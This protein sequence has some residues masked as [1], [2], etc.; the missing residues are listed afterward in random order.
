MDGFYQRPFAEMALRI[1][2]CQKG[3][4]PWVVAEHGGKVVV[5]IATQSKQH[6]MWSPDL[7][8]LLSV[9]GVINRVVSFL[10]GLHG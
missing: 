5:P 1:K 10:E 7:K 4:F 2:G 6:C 8:C 9:L 3:N